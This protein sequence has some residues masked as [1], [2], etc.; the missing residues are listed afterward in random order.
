MSGVHFITLNCFD[1]AD[2]LASQFTMYS[3]LFC[4]TVNIQYC[5]FF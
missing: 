1:Y 4:I 2:V 3:K 5:D